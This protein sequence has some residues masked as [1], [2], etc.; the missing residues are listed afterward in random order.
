MITPGDYLGFVTCSDF[1]NSLTES[2]SYR[3]DY[4]NQLVE[5]VDEETVVIL[6]N[7]IVVSRQP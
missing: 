7:V 1:S 2:C 4:D 5:V 6:Q 3:E